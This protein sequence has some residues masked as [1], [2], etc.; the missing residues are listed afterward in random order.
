M[1]KPARYELKKWLS[2]NA[3]CGLKLHYYQTGTDTA[4]TDWELIPV[5]GKS[6]RVRSDSVKD[7]ITIS[8]DWYRVL[9][10]SERYIKEVEEYSVFEKK[11]HKDLT[12]YKRLKKKFE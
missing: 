12:E 9:R 1:K 10:L 4:T 6:K 3:V 2:E 8:P 7:L 11:E 5:D